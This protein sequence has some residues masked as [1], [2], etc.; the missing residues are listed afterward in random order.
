MK[1][2]GTVRIR[3]AFRP[4][5]GGPDL[6]DDDFGDEDSMIQKKTTDHE[7]FGV[8]G[9]DGLVYIALAP[10]IATARRAAIRLGLGRPLL[11][12]EERAEEIN[13]RGRVILRHSDT[14]IE[15]PHAA[16]FAGQSD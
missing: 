11:D 2:G 7:A 15:A 6:R 1:G 9:Q 14:W 13:V 8:V 3:P 5:I 12:A 4:H 16:L 10:K